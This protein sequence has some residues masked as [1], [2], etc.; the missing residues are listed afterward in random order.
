MFS[1]K[2]ILEGTLLYLP[3]YEL[4]VMFNEAYVSKAGRGGGLQ[5][6]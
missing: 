5:G 3:Q 4:V 2:N 6:N 1:I